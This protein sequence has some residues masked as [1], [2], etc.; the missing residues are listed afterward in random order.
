M[1]E[2]RDFQKHQQQIVSDGVAIGY[3]STAKGGCPAIVIDHEDI[4][5]AVLGEL[6]RTLDERDGAPYPDRE[7]CCLGYGIKA[8]D[9]TTYA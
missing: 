4:A 2:I 5:P 8:K 1:I 9:V 6:F 7:A 3:V